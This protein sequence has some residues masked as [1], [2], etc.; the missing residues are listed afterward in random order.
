MHICETP[1]QSALAGYIRFAAGDL[2]TKWGRL[3]EAAAGDQAA[4]A[5]YR[6]ADFMSGMQGF[7]MLS[8]PKVAEAFDLSAFRT[9]VDLGGSTGHLALALQD[10]YPHL[11]IGVFDKPDMIEHTKA[12]TGDRAALYSGDFFADALPAADLYGLG[13]ILHNQAEE[14]IS[15]LLARIYNALPSAGALLVVERVLDDDLRGPKHVHMSSL[16]ML[17]ASHGRERTFSEYRGWL[18]Q[19]GFRNV[20]IKKTGALLDAMLAYK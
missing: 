1:V 17:V 5:E 11:K 3:A 13:K 7:G 12:Y 4:P 8:S 16:N 19:A 6:I 10:R 20:Q 18:E 14:K 2:Y 15:A 9:F